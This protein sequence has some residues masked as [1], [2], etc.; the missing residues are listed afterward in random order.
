MADERLPRL[1]DR[2]RRG[3][4]VDVQ[5]ESPPP[6]PGQ[7]TE[8]A[9]VATAFASVQRTAV[10]AAVGQAKLREGMNRLFLNLSRRNQSL[11]HRQL[12]MLD[13]MERRTSEPA[14]WPTCSSLITSPPGC[15]A[16]QRA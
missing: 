15:G 12:T 8:T 13:T 1:V 3:D 10:E 2:L 9:Q 6:I 14:S 7:I 11:L 5:A 4:A 16:T